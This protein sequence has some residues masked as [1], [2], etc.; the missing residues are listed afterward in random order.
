MLEC[1]CVRRTM[2]CRHLAHVIP[3]SPS[4]NFGSKRKQAARPRLYLLLERP[5]LPWA[6]DLS[7][8]VADRPGC[9]GR[10]FVGLRSSYN[11]TVNQ[12]IT[13]TAPRSGSVTDAGTGTLQVQGNTINGGSLIW[14]DGA[15]GSN[16]TLTDGSV[17]NVDL[18]DI[19]SFSGSARGGNPETAR[20]RLRWSAV[21]SQLPRSRP[22]C[23][24][25]VRV[26][27]GLAS[28]GALANGFSS[29]RCRLGSDGRGRLHIRRPVAPSQRHHIKCQT[30][31]MATS[32]MAVPMDTPIKMPLA[33]A[34]SS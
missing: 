32:H 33:D 19:A 10:R 28:C 8:D 25:W 31:K 5:M 4:A 1:R 26:S 9:R 2:Q 12:T 29:A 24:Y 15:S 27:S 6:T 17:M 22:V 34:R 7:A 3:V 11:F 23:W 21:R 13:F 14:S 16:V 20:L 30:T 18:S